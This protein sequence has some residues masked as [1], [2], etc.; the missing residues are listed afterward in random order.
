MPTT[1]TVAPYS[2]ECEKFRKRII[3]P[4]TNFE[5]S[6]FSQSCQ[7]LFVCQILDHRKRGYFLEIGGAHPA[8]ANNTLLLEQEYGWTGFAVEI[9]ARLVQLYNDHRESQCFHHDAVTFEYGRRMKLSGY[10][11]QIDYLSLDVDP[12]E[13]SY[14]ALLKCPFD[15]FRFSVITYEHDL[16]ASGPKYMQLSREFL[17]ARGYQLVVGNVNHFGRDFEDWWIDPTAVPEESWKR[18]QSS[19]IEFVEVFEKGGLVPP[20]G[21]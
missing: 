6:T 5:F 7:D 18:Y 1:T 21:P 17:R 11:A 20:D 15:G 16:Y 13:N 19:N 2:D 8:E 4:K 9:D 12:A 3:H 14:A 10:P